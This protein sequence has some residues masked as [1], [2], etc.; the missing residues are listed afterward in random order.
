MEKILKIL[1]KVFIKI[2][3]ALLTSLIILVLPFILI[4]RIVEKILNRKF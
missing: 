3:Y 4:I 1:K 2:C